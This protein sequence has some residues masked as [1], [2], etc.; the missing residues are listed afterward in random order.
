MLII[1]LPAGTGFGRPNPPFGSDFEV[2]WSSA[3][4]ARV[5]SGKVV[6]GLRV[7]IRS[8]LTASRVSSLGGGTPVGHEAVLKP[9]LL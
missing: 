6:V 7:G 5:P 2:A 8:A 4:F 3:G 1:M 9:S